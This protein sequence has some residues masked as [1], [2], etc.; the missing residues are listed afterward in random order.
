MLIGES[1]GSII[2]RIREGHET[3]GQ[4]QTNHGTGSGR[5]LPITRSAPKGRPISCVSCSRCAV[6]A[7]RPI[8]D[9]HRGILLRCRLRSVAEKGIAKKAGPPADPAFFIIRDILLRAHRQHT[10]LH[11]AFQYRPG[12]TSVSD[13]SPSCPRDRSSPGSEGRWARHAPSSIRCCC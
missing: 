1:R 8:Q 10:R 2:E 13:P 6:L 3:G 12:S 11:R 5:R 7:D 4:H 9:E